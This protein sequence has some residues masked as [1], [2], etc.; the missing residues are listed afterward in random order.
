[1]SQILPIYRNRVRLTKP[2]DV[3]KLLARTVNM[4]IDDELMKA[5]RGL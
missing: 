5:K 2:R 3:Q 4:L 1:M